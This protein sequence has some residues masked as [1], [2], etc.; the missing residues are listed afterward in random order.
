MC[1]STGHVTVARLLTSE[2]G[3]E[4]G[5]VITSDLILGVVFSGVCVIVILARTSN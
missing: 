2:S 3:L 4:A 1:Q 5:V